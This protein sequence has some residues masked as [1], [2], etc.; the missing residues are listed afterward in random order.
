MV[1]AAKKHPVP[2]PDKTSVSFIYEEKIQQLSE[3]REKAAVYLKENG[4]KDVEQTKITLFMQST[5]IAN[6]LILPKIEWQQID[7]QPY[8]FFIYQIYKNMQ[9]SY[10]L[11]KATKWT[12]N[13]SVYWRFQQV[14]ASFWDQAEIG[15]YL[16]S[17]WTID[18]TKVRLYEFLAFS[19]ALLS[20]IRISPLVVD[21]P[22][23][24]YIALINEIEEDNG[25]QIQLQV[26]M[27]KSMDVP[28]TLDQKEDVSLAERIKVGAV[29]QKFLEF[30][31]ER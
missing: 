18:E 5:K 24:D 8:K 17:N 1:M 15:R 10:L 13:Y 25:R 26:R 28:L 23:D 7:W 6:S 4:L 16:Q 12:L 19:H 2:M 9:S 27:L 14:A 31:C 30:L 20:Q 11:A 3:A 21:L 29:Y 22:V